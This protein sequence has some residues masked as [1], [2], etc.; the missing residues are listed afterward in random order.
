[1]TLPSTSSPISAWEINAELGRSTVASLNF[2]DVEVKTLAVAGNNLLSSTSETTTDFNSL[3]G[4]ARAKIVPSTNTNNINLKTS[5][6]AVGYASGKTY[7]TLLVAN[8]IVVGSTNTASPAVTIGTFTGNDV[9]EVVLEANGY[10]TGCGG[11]GGKG[12]GGFNVNSGSFDPGTDGGAGGTALYTR[13][14]TFV[15][16]LGNVWGGGGG[17]GGGGGSNTGGKSREGEG[18]GGG[19]GGAGQLGGA[20]GDGGTNS[21]GTQGTAGSVGSLAAGGAGG[22][23]GGDAGFG[24][25]G[26][27]PGLPGEQGLTSADGEAGTLGGDAG[28]YVDGSSFVTWVSVGSRL[29]GSI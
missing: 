24:G 1:M 19:G 8:N 20:A 23:P 15:N 5:V 4:T 21:A 16:N 29:G 9:V 2:N 27:G 25:T 10:I 14:N 7:A 26:G 6:D 11:A 28:N 22:P 12:I 13:F 3:R 18:G 17:A